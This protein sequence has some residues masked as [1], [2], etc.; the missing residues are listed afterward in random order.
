VL[1][2]ALTPA[3]R[4]L[5]VRPTLE[6][7]RRFDPQDHS[8]F[9]LEE[10]IFIATHVLLG[11]H[12]DVLCCSTVG[13]K[14]V[15]NGAADHNGPPRILRIDEVTATLGSRLMLFALRCLMTVLIRRSME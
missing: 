6:Y 8:G 10:R 1:I 14:L 7:M 5:S 12:V 15:D 4:S 2:L 9:A 13:T 11:E 3:A